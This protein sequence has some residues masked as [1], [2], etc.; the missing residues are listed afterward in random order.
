MS[1][2]DGYVQSELHFGSA[3]LHAIPANLLQV[4]MLCNKHREKALLAALT[5]VNN[6]HSSLPPTEQTGHAEEQPLVTTANDSLWNIYHFQPF[7]SNPVLT[8]SCLQWLSRP[9]PSKFNLS[10]VSW[11]LAYS[12]QCQHRSR[13]SVI[14]V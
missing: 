14:V 8:C 12:C 4:V 13:T 9:D 6:L 1:Y 7:Y 11:F 10:L 2:G 5:P 3:P